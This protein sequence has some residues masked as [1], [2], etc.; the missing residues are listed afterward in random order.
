MEKF[1]ELEFIY[2]TNEPYDRTESPT[3]FKMNKNVKNREDR[4][5]AYQHFFF[6]EDVVAKL[7]QYGEYMLIN[8][9]GDGGAVY[10]WIGDN[11]EEWFIQH[12]DTLIDIV[13]RNI[14][15]VIVHKKYVFGDNA[16]TKYDIQL[17][18]EGKNVTK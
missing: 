10:L 16:Y 17:K 18:V 15:G 8:E 14:T 2:S 5:L 9:H 4:Y 1:K 11:F 12:L 13:K 6:N 3:I 7:D